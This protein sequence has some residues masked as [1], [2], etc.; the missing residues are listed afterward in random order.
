MNKANRRANRAVHG[1][2]QPMKGPQSIADVMSGLLAKRG[3]AQTQAAAEMT[4]AWARAV[5]PQFAGQTAPGRIRNGVLEVIV[6]NSAVLQELTFE[7]KNV[8]NNLIEIVPEN[9]IRDLRFRIGPA[10]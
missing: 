2:Q 4:A 10:N 6:A 9:S 7:K 3:Y 1:D 8:L 5:G